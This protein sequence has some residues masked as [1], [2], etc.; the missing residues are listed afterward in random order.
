[1]NAGAHAVPIASVV[2]VGVAVAE[3]FE[4]SKALALHA[5]EVCG[6]AFS[7]SRFLAP[8]ATVLSAGYS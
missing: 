1:M 7:A 3:G 5:F 8:S 2:L 6:D 4:P